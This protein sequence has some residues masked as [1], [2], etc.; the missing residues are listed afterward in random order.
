M[1]KHQHILVPQEIGRHGQ[2]VSSSHKKIRI[3]Q[4]PFYD[5]SKELSDQNKD[6]ASK[7]SIWSLVKDLFH[8]INWPSNNPF[9]AAKHGPYQP[10]ADRALC[11]SNYGI[12]GK[13]LGE[14]ISSHVH[15]I[16][17]T[18][19]QQALAVKIFQK[20]KRKDDQVRYMKALVS[21]FA[22]SYTLKHVNILRTLDFVKIGRNRFGLVLDYCN[23]G[24]FNS[25]MCGRGLD[26]KEVHAYFKQLLNGVKYLHDAGVAH[27]DLKPDNLLLDGHI[28]KIGDFG[29]CDVF[30][31]EGERTDAMS[32]GRVGTTPYMAPEIFKG[33][34]YWGAMADIWSIGI[35]FFSMH[36]TCV[37]FYSAR[38]QDSNFRQYLRTYDEKKYP[39]FEEL[40]SESKRVL[41]NI[42][43]PDSNKR[44]NILSILNDPWVKSLDSCYVRESERKKRIKTV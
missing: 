28:L 39:S 43:N 5:D 15:L 41:Y 38:I 24:D 1:Y 12:I 42:L 21:E 33:G 34:S 2:P 37:P 40:P 6:W 36:H 35:I 27:R 32:R 14:G 16:R 7:R 13:S 31:A 9:Q 22:V 3:N 18:S 26:S 19:D 30:R 44:P 23:Q 10:F 29:S 8:R 17:S 20:C 4:T 25:L 11:L